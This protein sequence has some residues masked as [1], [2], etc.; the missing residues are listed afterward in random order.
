M[1]KVFVD[2]TGTIWKLRTGSTTPQQVPLPA[3]VT[4]V[5]NR[6]PT[7]DTYRNRLYMAGPWNRPLVFTEDDKIW[8]AG[9]MPP[10][11]APVIATS[12]AGGIN[13]A[14]CYGY[15]VFREKTPGGRLVAESNPGPQ[16]N[17]LLDITNVGLLVSQVPTTAPEARVTH[18]GFYRSDGGALPKLAAEFMLGPSAFMDIV[19]TVSLAT[20]EPLP[21]VSLSDGSV[22][23]TLERGVPPNCRLIASYRDRFFYGG[24]LTHPNRLYYS[25]LFEPE[26]VGP[27]S[28]INTLDGEAITAIK[29]IGDILLV[30]CRRS[31]YELQ[32]WSGEDF[33]LRKLHPSVGCISPWSVVNIN[34]RL[35]FAAEQGVYVFD[36]GFRFVMDAIKL[37]WHV[38][39]KANPNLFELCS[40]VEDQEY[41]CYK[42]L[43]PY[44][45]GNY[46]YVG[47]YEQ[48][49][50]SLG[51]GGTEVLWS[52]DTRAR[53]DRSQGRLTTSGTGKVVVCTGSS[54]GKVREENDFTD[55]DDDGDDDAK[56]VELRTKHFFFDDPGGDM[57]EGKQ[58][59]R[60]WS[61]VKSEDSSWIFRPLGGD[62][63]TNSSEWT[64]GW[65][66]SV[67]ASL[68]SGKVAKTRHF[69]PPPEKVSGHGFTFVYK[70][71]SPLNWAFRGVGGIVGPGVSFR[72]PSS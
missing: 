61:Y 47:S 63:E 48:F 12:G 26:A 30:F 72:G 15:F 7:G 60:A 19:S 38:R 66:D 51:A 2:A 36:G 64:G 14:A 40:G 53:Y 4:G 16:S 5:P 21:N 13:T 59:V 11:T 6:P 23:I 10:A 28:Y 49:D 1:A 67:A 43:I 35:W 62:E 32:G 68:S 8:G 55:A 56:I 69:H 42:L 33:K 39:F 45:T 20:R 22:S 24:I 70:A 17:I 44:S 31:C 52:I 27:T 65:S 3:G 54:D 58:L 46:T 29:K 57:E 18:V 34:E 41:H 25:K 9:I 37:D 50:P 71:T